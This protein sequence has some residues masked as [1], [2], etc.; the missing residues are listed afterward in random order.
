M[1]H[2]SLTDN[3]RFD[4]NARPDTYRA[5]YLVNKL[6]SEFST[7]SHLYFTFIVFQELFQLLYYYDAF[8]WPEN[9]GLRVVPGAI[10]RSEMG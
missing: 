10:D 7:A 4:N 6:H 8:A 9:F 5:L 1:Y 2:T 3:R